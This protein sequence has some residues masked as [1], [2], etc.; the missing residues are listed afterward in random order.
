MIF[1]IHTKPLLRLL[2]LR[3]VGSSHLKIELALA[4]IVWGEIEVQA[5]PGVFLVELLN[6]RLQQV[7]FTVCD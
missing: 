2:S 1:D 5:L 7:C 3:Q 6:P 4:V